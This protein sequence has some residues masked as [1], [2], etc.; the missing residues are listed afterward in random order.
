[1]F[2]GAALTE[3]IFTGNILATTAFAA[4]QLTMY[5][6]NGNVPVIFELSQQ[7]CAYE[8]MQWAHDPLTTIF[9]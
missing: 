1:M 6:T 2:G 9:Y 4:S 8:S 5:L 3:F 7:I